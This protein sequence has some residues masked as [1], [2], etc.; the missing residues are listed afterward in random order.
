MT[1]LK[2]ENAVA[3]VSNSNNF[4]ADEIENA[5]SELYA[6][7]KS[8]LLSKVAY[9]FCRGD[10]YL[11]EDAFQSSMV[12]LLSFI[13]EERIENT[14]PKSLFKWM[15]TSCRYYVLDWYKYRK[16]KEEDKDSNKPSNEVV[17]FSQLDKEE[18]GSYFEYLEHIADESHL[19]FDP[20]RYSYSNEAL[21]QVHKVIKN[22]ILNPDQRKVFK[23]CVLEDK[24]MQEVADELGMNIN[25]VKSNLRYAR[26]AIEMFRQ[27][28]NYNPYDY[29]HEQ[30][31]VN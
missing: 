8:Q 6:S 14:S 19:Y 29:V 4:A 11:A 3:I 7:L 22:A 27:K 10:F 2:I 20:A 17:C 24:K 26:K 25:T 9:D 28:N 13:K 1:N 23:L 18:D 16:E 5:V 12:K 30:K 21:N 31:V 15:R